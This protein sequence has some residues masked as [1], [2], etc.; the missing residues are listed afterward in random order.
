MNM[1]S[2]S[3]I[4]VLDEYGNC[5]G[6]RASRK[7]VHQ[8]GL[9]HRAV[10]LYLVDETNHLLMQRRSLKVDHYPGEWSISLTGHV[11]AGESSS[12]A[13]Y[14]EVKEELGLDPVHM[15]FEFLFS[16]RQDHLTNQAYIDRQFNDVYFCKYP[17]RLDQIF[18]NTD[19]VS[20]LE[21]ISLSDFKTK[22]AEEGALL[23]QL[24]SRECEILIYLKLM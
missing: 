21:R 15:K 13:L 7:E 22:V 5:T 17:F 9:I 14:R 23:N 2:P 24:Y 8:Q 20:S 16:Y 3:L 11:D 12:A 6:Q 1:V 4:D 10:H 18:F 19:E